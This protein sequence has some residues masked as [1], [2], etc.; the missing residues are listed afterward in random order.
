MRD[1]SGNVMGVYNNKT[2]KEQA[3]YG[4]SR[5]GLI[6]YASKTGYRT[7]GG[8]KYELSN[9][10][11]NVLAVVRDNIHLDQD[12]TWTTAINTTDY[13]PF[14]LAMDS[15][16]VQD[17]TYRYGFNGK[18]QDSSGEWGGQSHYDYG[19]R[20]YNPSIAKFLSVDPLAKG[21]PMLT[22]YQYASNTPIQAIDLDGLEAVRYPGVGTTTEMLQKPTE[23]EVRE[24]YQAYKGIAL[25]VYDFFNAFRPQAGMGPVDPNYIPVYSEAK[26]AY[27]GITNTIENGSIE[28]KFR[29]G[30]VGV[31]SVYG[32]AE[33]F[34]K[35]KMPG[36]Q[37]AG[38]GILSLGDDFMASATKPWGNQGLTN[39]GRALQKHAGREGSTFQEI[40]FSHKTA[41]QDG[42]NIINQIKNS[43]KQIIQ[44][45]ENGGTLI[46]DETS[47]MG[48]GVSRDG[49]FNG[50]REL[51]K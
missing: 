1:A 15:R 6:N 2:L 5:L 37:G 39:V 11:G 38:K 48:F 17:S 12:S 24:V 31:L 42:L 23:Q 44:Q 26:E 3:I 13:Y 47:G 49:L 51:P 32:G 45:A 14:G 7:L 34:T 22:P 19:F 46:F 36:V 18:E 8:K 29:L 27:S 4:S 40:K 10:L 35:F 33:A 25:G 43:P 30:T 21:Y 16:I 20:I 41:N 28:D 50:F 9:H